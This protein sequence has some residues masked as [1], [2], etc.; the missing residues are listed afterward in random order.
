MNYETVEHSHQPW[1]D[2]WT[3]VSRK[4][5]GNISWYKIQ[6]QLGNN[7]TKSGEEQYRLPWR[8]G[9]FLLDH[10]GQTWV[11]RLFSG[12][13]DVQVRKKRDSPME[14]DDCDPPAWIRVKSN[15][16][17]SF[18]CCY[19]FFLFLHKIGKHI[20][21]NMSCWNKENFKTYNRS[22]RV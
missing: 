17:I 1:E 10:N 7:K 11:Y 2:M 14:E 18:I 9:F 21:Q 5:R 13:T 4:M 12:P 20:T 3:T 22:A 19:N 8:S 6:K 16:T 15:A